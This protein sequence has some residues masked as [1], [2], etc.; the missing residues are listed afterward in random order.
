[1]KRMRLHQQISTTA[2]LLQVIIAGIAAVNSLRVINVYTAIGSPR[3]PIL[4]LFW[5]TLLFV[6][7]AA[8]NLLLTMHFEQGRPSTT[9]RVL[10]A[11]SLSAAPF[12]I[13]L[14]V[15]LF[16]S[17]LTNAQVESIRGS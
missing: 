16:L 2:F 8:T 13:A 10:L 1:M 15:L 6:T 11:L 5:P 7:F 9:R 14:L 12:V 3:P 4:A 17:L